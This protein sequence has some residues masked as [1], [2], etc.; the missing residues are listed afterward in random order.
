MYLSLKTILLGAAV[1]SAIPFPPNGTH[2]VTGPK[3]HGGIFGLPW[4]K[5]GRNDTAPKNVTEFLEVFRD[6]FKNGRNVTV[7]NGTH[8]VTGTKAHPTIFGLP[9]IKPGHNDTSPKTSA[10]VLEALLDAFKNGPNV[11]VIH[12]GPWNNWTDITTNVTKH[13][14]PKR[15][16]HIKP[17]DGNEVGHPIPP[18]KT[19]TEVLLAILEVIKNGPNGTDTI[20][21]IKY[22]PNGTVIINVP[23][24]HVPKPPHHVE[25]RDSAQAAAPDA[26]GGGDL[27]CKLKCLIKGDL[28]CAECP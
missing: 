21:V 13:N 18:P 23:E 25:R 15:P 11:T 14:L 17:Q 9:W 1:A 4:L 16:H 20:K 5:P 24:H 7:T 28:N 2:N 6:L 8:N 12:N 27:F 26:L 10:E 19:F 3:A 22:G